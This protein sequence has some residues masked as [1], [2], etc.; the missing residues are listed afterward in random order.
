MGEEFKTL[1]Y[2]IR[3]TKEELEDFFVKVT[4]FKKELALNIRTEKELL[5]SR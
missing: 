5:N 4:L 1:P 2:K 3:G